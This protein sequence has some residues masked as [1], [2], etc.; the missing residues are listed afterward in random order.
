MESKNTHAVISQALCSR[1]AIYAASYGRGLDG[2]HLSD[3]GSNNIL[4]KNT[5]S[6]VAD[7]LG[8]SHALISAL[9]IDSYKGNAIVVTDQHC[10][11][12]RRRR[13]PQAACL[14]PA[15]GQG[16]AQTCV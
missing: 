10:P 3:F 5:P 8:G 13:S 6:S 2:A 15:A 14:T 7:A 12:V 16:M 11:G 4:T 9:A 1:T